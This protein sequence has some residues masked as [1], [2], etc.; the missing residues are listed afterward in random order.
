MSGSGGFWRDQ[1]L[2]LDGDPELFFPVRRQGP[3]SHTGLTGQ[4]RLRRMPRAGR[5]FGLGATERH[6]QR[7][8]GWAGRSR[9]PHCSAQSTSVCSSFM[10][11]SPSRRETF[12]ATDPDPDGR[13]APVSGGRSRLVQ[14]ARGGQLHNHGNEAIEKKG[15]QLVAGVAPSATT[16]SDTSSAI[17][18]SAAS[19]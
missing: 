6:R 1:A 7:D 4:T 19:C 16:S 8:L 14:T 9:T 10:V 3:G 12:A 5:M 2:C 17:V 11:V 18:G 15:H 13:P